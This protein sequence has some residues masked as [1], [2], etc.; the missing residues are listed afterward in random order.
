MTNET[1]PAVLARL[2]ATF[3]EIERRLNGDILQVLMDV[4]VDALNAREWKP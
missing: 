4:I 3:R 1:P 2:E